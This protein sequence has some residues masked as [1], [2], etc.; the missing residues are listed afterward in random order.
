MH[1]LEAYGV[2]IVR[3]HLRDKQGRRHAHIR[4]WQMRRERSS[5]RADSFEFRLPQCT[6]STYGDSV[7]SGS[8]S[9]PGPRKFAPGHLPRLT[10]AGLWAR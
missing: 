1:M 3:L 4:A 8:L 9:R 2:I 10:E 6:R 7:P 5:R